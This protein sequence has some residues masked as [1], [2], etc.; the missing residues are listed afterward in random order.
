MCYSSTVVG[1]K[2]GKMHAWAVFC[3]MVVVCVL[4]FRLRLC[5]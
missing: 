4:T 5:G 2:D 1:L 3:M